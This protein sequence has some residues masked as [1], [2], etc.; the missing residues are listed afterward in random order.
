MKQ[1]LK[2]SHSLRRP[3]LTVCVCVRVPVNAGMLRGGSCFPQTLCRSC[4]GAFFYFSVRKGC[5]CDV[6]RVFS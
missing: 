2:G 3:L 4:V 1:S 5:V 6:G